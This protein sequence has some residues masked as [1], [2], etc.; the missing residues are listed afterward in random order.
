MEI[1]EVTLQQH[2]PLI[3]FQHYQ[4]GATLRVSEVKPQLDRY[5][6]TILGAG[7]YE[8]GVRIADTYQ[9]LKGEHS[10]LNYR[11][12]IQPLNRSQLR[13]EDINAPAMEGNRY[14]IKRD[15]KISLK[16][17]PSYFANMNADYTI[18]EE[19]RKFSIT[20]QLE[21][22]LFFPKETY[23]ANDKSLCTYIKGNLNGFF[24][25][26]NFG[27]RASKGFGSFYINKKDEL[28]VKPEAL[29]NY[30][31]YKFSFSCNDY[32]Y[33]RLGRSDYEKLFKVIEVFYKSLRSGINEKD[34]NDN[35]LFYF[36]S[37]AYQ[38]CTNVLSKKWDKRTIKEAFYGVSK[39][40]SLPSCDIKDVFGFSTIEEWRTIKNCNVRN[41]TIKKSTSS[42][43][44]STRMQ[45]PLLFKPFYNSQ[46]K[47]YDIYIIF[48]EKQVELE[49]FLSNKSVC[50][51][52]KKTG[53]KDIQ[54]E[55]PKTFSLKA[56]FEY[57]INNF[58][59][60]QYVESEY[61]DHQYFDILSDIFEQLKNNSK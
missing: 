31:S 32:S 50:V 13:Y 16:S 21:M 6:L 18:P 8:E 14:R 33:K 45:S 3:H 53:L 60:P 27:T 38:Y 52:S 2:T 25:Q 22:V 26:T 4:D 9:W 44:K 34:R 42:P 10:A 49:R 7:D 19:Y 15:G 56:F 29:P 1:L 28:Y 48:K 30:T 36:K 54:I 55:L 35:T 17:Y 24:L 23:A 40:S 51:K 59:I 61:H 20:D 58:D 39:D 5:I 57:I 46:N 11:M 43:L 12:K 41:D 37:L 47:G